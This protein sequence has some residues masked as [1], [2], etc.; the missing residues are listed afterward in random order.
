MD[1]VHDPAY[2]ERL[3]AE[4]PDE[5]LRRREFLARTA[6]AAGVGA[7]G[8]AALGPGTLVAQAARLEARVPLPSPRNIPIDTFVVVMMENRSF[9]HFLGWLPKADGR[10]AGLSYVDAQGQ[11]KFT[12]NLAPDYQGCGHPTPGH[13]WP[14][15]R[16]QFND[17][18][19][20][21]FLAAGSG[22]D[23]FAIGYY[24]ERDVPLLAALTRN[25]T[26]FDRYFSSLLGSTNPNRSYMHAAQSYGDKFMFAD[27][28]GDGKP[29]PQF[30]TPP[31]R[32]FDTT[33]HHRLRQRGLRAT[34]FYSDDN[35]GAMWGPKGYRDS[36][37]L[38]DYFQRAATGRLPALSFVD[39]QLMNAK[40]ALGVSNDQHNVSDIRTGEWFMSDVV[41]AFLDSPQWRRGALFLVYDEWGGYFDHV[42]PP[43]VPDARASSDVDD[44]FGQMGFR[45]PAVVLSPWA[46][47][48]A[49]DHGRFGHESI[50]KF[51]E[52]RFG[53]RPL[54]VRDARANNI[55]AALR[56]PTQRRRD[57]ALTGAGRRVPNSDPPDLPRARE[58]N[59]Q[60]CPS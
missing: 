23:E 39:P 3:G 11:R 33:I 41:H 37:P 2:A 22:N 19:C 56:F 9:D 5:L 8:L 44:D 4:H 7:A 16:V 60:A 17:G 38:A 47:R 1:D 25:G 42:R 13:T 45:T 57:V 52:Y 50:L 26:T 30:P 27:I 14:Q 15:G 10:Q 46:R 28:P 35:Y 31:G 55:G 51:V 58:W 6:M 53:L 24:R 36:A 49:V 12:R 29:G 59:S 48:G 20:D 21:G 18:R 43:S 32:P 34:T 54:T 40:E